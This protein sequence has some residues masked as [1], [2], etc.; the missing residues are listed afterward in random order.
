[1]K[2][3]QPPFCIIKVTEKPEELL[4]VFASK[5]EVISWLAQ[6]FNNVLHLER[7]YKESY[8]PVSYIKS[9]DISLEQYVR[10]CAIKSTHHL[11][12]AVHCKWLLGHI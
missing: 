1:M 11:I 6:Y 10:D 7:Q 9:L 3:L 5:E 8:Q 12:L 4:A 2:Y